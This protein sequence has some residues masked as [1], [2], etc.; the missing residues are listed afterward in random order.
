[1]RIDFDKRIDWLFFGLIFRPVQSSIWC[2]KTVKALQAERP[3][4]I[5]YSADSTG[6]GGYCKF[7]CLAYATVNAI[8]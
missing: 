3:V 2:R 5:H 4:H 7:M 6:G 8:S 1:M